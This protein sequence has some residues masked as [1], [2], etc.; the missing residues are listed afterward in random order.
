MPQL[1]LQADPNSK[2][3]ALS[4]QKSTSRASSSNTRAIHTSPRGGG[5]DIA[6]RKAAYT[7][8]GD[9][10]NLWELHHI[11]E[12]MAAINKKKHF[13]DGPDAKGE[14]KGQPDRGT[15]REHSPEGGGVAGARETKRHKNAYEIKGKVATYED[16]ARTDED[17]PLD[18][19]TRLLENGQEDVPKGDCVVY[20]MR[21]EDMRIE[22]NTA[23]HRA[24]ERAQEFGVPLVVLFVLSPGDYK[25][26]DRSTK[27]ID[28]MLRNL[29][30]LKPRLHELDIPLHIVSYDRRL[31]IP[32]RLVND[33]FPSLGAKHLFA[34]IEYEVDELRRD[35]AVVKLG[36]EKGMDVRCLHDRLIVPP[37]RIKS[38]AGKPMSVF[39]P[40][41]RAWAKLLAAEPKLLNLSPSPKA[42][43]ES[44][45]KDE[46]FAKLFDDEIPDSVEGF[47]CAERKQIAEIFPE[48][49]ETAKELL[50][51]FLHTKPRKT[52]FQIVSP[53]SEG[54]Q[55]SKKESRVSQYQTGRNLVDGDNSSRLSPYL[56]SG[57]ISGRMVLDEA[58][59]YTGGKLESGRDTGVGMWVQ[60]VSWRDFYNHVMSTWPRVSM[61][62]P[63]L[64][65]FADV[66]WEVNEE[67]LQAW[68][69]GK[70]GYPIVDAAMRACKARGWMENRVRMVSASFLV[71]SLMLDWRLGEKYFMESFIDGDLAANN[72]G[73]QWTASTGTDPQPY[74]RIFNTLTQS[75]KCDPN[76]DYIRY[77]VPEL[78]NLK[79]KAVHDPYHQM[80]S[81]EFKKLGYPAPIV[82]HKKS[83]E[84]AL[85]RYKNVGEKED[86]S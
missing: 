61:G 52:Q 47:E 63:F 50:R 81:S 29:R 64:E 43:L 32:K 75:E 33:V 82:D 59:K 18:Q 40:W 12:D 72:G 51:R 76:G 45:K 35:I 7:K 8:K 55:E 31:S 38:Q 14:S 4:P 6:K 10:P 25:I 58:K 86:G 71:K 24:S 54:A 66:Q 19:L 15:K 77:W 37:G 27:R 79:G 39:S 3:L 34:N 83:R 16:A 68:K 13:K 20:W 78:K 60:E 22:D 23:F 1:T 5:G 17:P 2:S 42:N 69:D 49:T 36:R 21:M 11:Q 56:A 48:G 57:V 41:Q 67:H 26:H 85:F 53:L 70:T 9:E 73:W 65:K 80:P 44:V 30:Y 84:R 62:R 74:F 46:R 28:F